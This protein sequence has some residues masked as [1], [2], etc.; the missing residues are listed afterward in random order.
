MQSIRE[1]LSPLLIISYVLG[2]RLWIIEF[3]ISYLRWWFSISYMLLYW[4]IYCFLL[5]F[6][7]ISYTTNMSYSTAYLICFWLDILITLLSVVFGVYHNKVRKFWHKFLLY[8]IFIICNFIIC[9]SDILIE[10]KRKL[11]YLK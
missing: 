8:V 1:I 11:S 9:N 5:K 7:V 10:K 4:L 6:T 2:L 3:P